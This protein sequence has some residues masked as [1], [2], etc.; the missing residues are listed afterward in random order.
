MEIIYLGLGSNTGDREKYLKDAQTRLS[1]KIIIRG[2]S[3]IYETKPL[4]C[5]PQPDFLNMVLEAR[6]E[7]LP[8]DLLAF[9][10]KVETEMGRSPNSHNQP[11]IIDIDILLYGQ[12]R[13]NTPALT[14]PHP[15]LTERAF[16]MLPLMELAADFIYPGSR[17]SL[18]D[19][20]EELPPGQSIRLFSRLSQD[21]PDREED[22]EE[23]D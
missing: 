7:L 5:P 19:L 4:D 6:T 9:T 17:L 14:I 11:R 16:V 8:Q 2:L 20:L 22:D 12:K 10:Q 18:S 21:G 15:R 23:D 13:L 3:A 1:E